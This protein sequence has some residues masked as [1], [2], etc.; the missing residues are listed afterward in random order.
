[1]ETLISKEI[2]EEAINLSN[3][4]NN[5]GFVVINKSGVPEATV[6]NNWKWEDPKREVIA[7][8]N[9]NDGFILKDNS[10]TF[11]TN[12]KNLL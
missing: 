5:T 4:W 8:V 1:M 11:E 9:E 6:W 2:M 7:Y 12:P 10:Y 3:E